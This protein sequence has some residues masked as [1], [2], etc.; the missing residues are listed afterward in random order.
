MTRVFGVARSRTDVQKKN[1][2][3]GRVF[4]QMYRQL[5]TFLLDKLASAAENM[6]CA[7]Q[8]LQPCLYPILML[9][10]RLNS[11]T[12]HASDSLFQ[13]ILDCV[14]FYSNH[15][16]YLIVFIFLVGA[17]RSTGAALWL[18]LRVKDAPVGCSGLGS[19]GHFR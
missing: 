4:F 13:V 14:A 18:M 12:C 9:L 8:S 11:P 17:I 15:A 10:A 6:H 1:T 2:L 5:Y 7:S 16:D 19:F 3:T